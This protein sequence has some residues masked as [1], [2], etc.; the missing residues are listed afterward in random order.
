MRIHY[1][2]CVLADDNQAHASN[3]QVN[4]T[5]AV[6]VKEL[7]QSTEA[8]VKGRGNQQVSLGF[9]VT[10]Q[11]ANASAAAKFAAG[12]P[13]ILPA[14]DNCILYWDNLRIIYTAAA[15]KAVAGAQI[16]ASLQMNYTIA[17]SSVE[18]SGIIDAYQMLAGGSY[19]RPESPAEDDTYYDQG[20]G[21][22]II[23]DGTDWRDRLGTLITTY[24]YVVNGDFSA[25][26]SYWSLINEETCVAA[27]AVV[28]GILQISPSAISAYV[29]NGRVYQGIANITSNK[30]YRLQM[31]VKAASART[32]RIVVG[33]VAAYPLIE[34]YNLTTDWIDIDEVFAGVDTG[35]NLRIEVGNA[36]P[37]VYVDDIS[38]TKVV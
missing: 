14:Q 1:G 9:N 29:W 33:D 27:M 23:Y 18:L 28:D 22:D 36:L 25:G 15:L 11:F 20:L 17:A 2:N 3:L 12:W 19:D 24:N 4:N 31:R 21:Y 10:Y 26:L 13:S 32:I 6:D 30:T 38:I 35:V 34:T 7:V 37:I 16:G 5:R 8:Y